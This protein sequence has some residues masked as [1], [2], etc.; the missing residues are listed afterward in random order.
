MG[1]ING[2]RFT[3]GVQVS[4]RQFVERT[5]KYDRRLADDGGFCLSEAGLRQLDSGNGKR[6]V[7]KSDM[8]DLVRTFAPV[9]IGQQ[10]FLA[11]TITGTLYGQDGSSVSGSSMRI[12]VGQEV[13]G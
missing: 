4:D 11:D 9:D 13:C 3:L 5:R 12:E 10:I 7:L 1:M 8:G 2:K 6:L